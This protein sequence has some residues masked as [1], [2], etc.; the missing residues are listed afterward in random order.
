MHARVLR[1][2]RMPTDDCSI[3]A[4][5]RS[6]FPA[7]SV[8]NSSSFQRR[9]RV[10][11]IQ[12]PYGDGHIDARCGRWRCIFFPHASIP[13]VASASH[14]QVRAIRVPDSSLAVPVVQPGSTM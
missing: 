10:H 9:E 4:A 13:P 3:L 2:G 12:L 7:A 1:E 8:G 5:P 11:F 6:Y 14:I